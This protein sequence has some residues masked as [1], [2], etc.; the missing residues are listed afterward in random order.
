MPDLTKKDKK[1]QTSNLHISKAAAVTEIINLRHLEWF[2]LASDVTYQKAWYYIA[3][4]D[5][6]TTLLQ[7]LI[8]VFFK[9]FSDF[10][11]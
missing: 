2:Q 5:A 1:H 7:K 3:T 11:F 9:H 10:L 6:E 8:V 4:Q